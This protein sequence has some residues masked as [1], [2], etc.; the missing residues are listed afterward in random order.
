LI[1]RCPGCGLYEGHTPSCKGCVAVYWR[2]YIKIEQDGFQTPEDAE[3]F[4]Q[5]GEDYG[6]LASVAI[7]LPDGTVW[8][9]RD[10]L[11]FD[12]P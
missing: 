11:G 10:T 4:L 2:H 7:L 6:E 9:S 12:W 5:S 1:Q 3:Q 8:K